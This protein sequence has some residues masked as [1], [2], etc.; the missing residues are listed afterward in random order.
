MYDGQR[1][2]ERERERVGTTRSRYADS[3]NLFWGLG[4]MAKWDRAYSI[5][6]TVD[7]KRGQANPADGEE[8]TSETSCDALIQA[9]IKPGSVR[10]GFVEIA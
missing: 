6:C 4:V 2:R 1:E 9:S 10:H 5:L 7:A 3:K 8:N